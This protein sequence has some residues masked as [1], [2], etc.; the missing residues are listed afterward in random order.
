MT[1]IISILL[2]RGYDYLA[3]IGESLYESAIIADA[4]G[5]VAA[6]AKAGFKR[7]K[8]RWRPALARDFIFS[9]YTLALT[10][11]VVRRSHAAFDLPPGRRVRGRPDVLEG[12]GPGV[13]R[14]L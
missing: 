5:C 6:R 12:V 9:I 13:G 10:S 14:R 11:Q 1:Q 4:V 2:F 8:D 3:G 7:T